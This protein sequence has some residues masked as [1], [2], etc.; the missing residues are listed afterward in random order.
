MIQRPATDV[1]VIMRKVRTSSRWQ[2]WRWELED[3]VENEEA[4]GGEPR[5]LHRD[6]SGERWLHPGFRLELFRDDGEGYYLNLTSPAPCFS[7]C[8]G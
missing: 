3:V 1:A 2:E 6:A 4:F 8:F 7:S 5:L